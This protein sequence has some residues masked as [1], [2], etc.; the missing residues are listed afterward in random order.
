MHVQLRNHQPLRIGYIDVFVVSICVYITFWWFSFLVY[1]K[2]AMLKPPADMSVIPCGYPATALE[3]SGLHGWNGRCFS[4]VNQMKVCWFLT[5]FDARFMDYHWTIP[6]LM[7]FVRF[8]KVMAEITNQ[9]A[10]ADV[11]SSPQKFST[12]GRR[13]STSQLGTVGHLIS[14]A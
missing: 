4:H 13:L 11:V 10:P 9:T 14:S 8:P 5:H 2:L 3:A 6:T 12:P 7:K 1:T